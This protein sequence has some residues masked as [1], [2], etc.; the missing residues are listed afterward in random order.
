L[1]LVVGLFVLAAGCGTTLDAS[2]YATDCDADTQCTVVRVGDICS[3]SCDITAIN[4]R[5]FDKYVSDLERIGACRDPC[6][7]SDPDASFTCGAGIGAVCSVGTC[8][9]APLPS[10]AGAD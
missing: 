2:N 7:S 3:C 5:D 6:V 4:D 1:R 8:V 10:D 9:T